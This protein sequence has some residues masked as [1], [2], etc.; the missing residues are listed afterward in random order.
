MRWPKAMCIVL[1]KFS[2][3]TNSLTINLEM[4]GYIEIIENVHQFDN[5]E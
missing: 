2:F 5:A 3:I 1:C 4:V